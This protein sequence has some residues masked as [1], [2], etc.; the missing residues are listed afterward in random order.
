MFFKKRKLKQAEVSETWECIVKRII[1]EQSEHERVVMAHYRHLIG[2][3]A[4]HMQSEAYG[5]ITAIR[6]DR[7]ADVITIVDGG[8]VAGHRHY[9]FIEGEQNAGGKLFEELKDKY[10]K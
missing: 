2:R 1:Q 5:V 6:F 4:I 10:F 7:Y 3:R 8:K 9:F